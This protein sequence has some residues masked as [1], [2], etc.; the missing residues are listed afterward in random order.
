LLFQLLSRVMFVVEQRRC[1]CYFDKWSM[2]LSV[3]PNA[4]PWTAF[5]KWDI[6]GNYTQPK[7]R[8]REQVKSTRRPTRFLGKAILRL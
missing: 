3:N 4:A 5:L 2:G 1:A 6:R 7:K 8:E